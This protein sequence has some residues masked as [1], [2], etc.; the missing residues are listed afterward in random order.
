MFHRY[1]AVANCLKTA[2]Q[3]E[4]VLPQGLKAGSGGSSSSGAKYTYK[5]ILGASRQSSSAAAAPGKEKVLYKRWQDIPD[6][7]I[8]TTSK[9]DPHNTIYRTRDYINF[10]KQQI[11]FQQKD[12][13]PIYLKRGPIAYLR[14]YLVA[15][16]AFGGSAYFVYEWARRE[17][18][19]MKRK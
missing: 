10:R 5:P 2:T 15:L 16:G 14:Y 7:M 13:I 18:T 3:L 8:P 4:A 17:L 19:F 11:F 9:R 1:N 12:G 6:S